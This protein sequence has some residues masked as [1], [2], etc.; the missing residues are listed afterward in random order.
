MCS[1]KL[2]AMASELLKDLMNEA[3][4]VKPEAKLSEP[5]NV[6]KREFFCARFALSVNVL[7]S[8]LKM[9][10]FSAR[11]EAIVN[12]AAGFRVQTV[13]TPACSVQETGVVV[14]AWVEV[15]IVFIV[16]MID[17]VNVLN[18]ELLSARL[19]TK[20]RELDRDLMKAP[21]SAK[22]E[23]NPREAPSDLKK[24]TILAKLE[25]RER[26]PLRLFA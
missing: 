6:R 7:A 4:S 26:V 8:V 17:P 25:E 24:G 21:F 23:T 9:V 22:P 18:R 16:S 1:V 13:A 5:V 15:N 3:R 2:E 20:L 11:P 14:E 12:D 10:F 19:E